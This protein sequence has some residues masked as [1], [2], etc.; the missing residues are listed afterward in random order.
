MTA[1]AAALGGNPIA[2]WD[3]DVN[4][5]YSNPALLQKNM[6]R[7]LSANYC[8]YVADMN[9][10]YVGY[11]HHL[12]D[13][14][15]SVGGG[16]QFYN[17]GKIQGY[18]EFDEKTKM[19]Q[20]NDY[21]LSLNYSKPM[22][23]T[24]FNIG[25]ALKTV[26][27]QY[28]EFWSMGNAV[29][30]GVTY[31]NKKNLTASIVA[32][33]IGV[34]YKNYSNINGVKEKLPQTVQLGLSYKLA[35]APIRLILT[36]DQLLKWNLNYISPVDT[37]GKNSSFGQD[38]NVKKDSSGWQKFQ[39]RFG[40]KSDVFMRHVVIGTEILVTKN[41]HIRLAYNY[42]RQKEFRLPERRGASGLSVG[43]G[44]NIKRFGI[45]YGFNKMA[46]AGNSSIFSFTYKL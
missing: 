1:R 38:K 14:L 7:Q 2:I 20:A 29:D 43:F 10:G 17:Y 44:F 15:G 33:N 36:Y 45:S 8:N 35:K 46:I 6:H 9:F 21:M 34:I 4:L 11:A 12:G 39:E 13:K 5:M 28:D 41:I 25:V 37:A 19:T 23:D 32:K 40:N 3:N 16:L 26:Y 27:S 30:F 31:H 42:R 24:S 22:D 18:D